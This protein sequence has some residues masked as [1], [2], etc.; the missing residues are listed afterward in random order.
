MGY[1]SECKLRTVWCKY[2]GSVIG[3]IDVELLEERRGRGPL[4]Q[5]TPHDVLDHA[6]ATAALLDEVERPG[7]QP[8]VTFAY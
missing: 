2:L 1:T 3:P 5:A 6:Q 7:G 4:S 8:R